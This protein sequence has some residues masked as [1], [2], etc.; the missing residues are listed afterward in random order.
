M[1]KSLEELQ[2][3]CEKIDQLL[4][5]ANMFGGL[6]KLD[7]QTITSEELEELREDLKYKIAAEIS[8]RKLRL[9]K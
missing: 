4:R 7:D 9:A 8:Q 1:S 5:I 2:N 6:I 3:S